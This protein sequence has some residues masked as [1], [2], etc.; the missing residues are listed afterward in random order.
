MKQIEL[1]RGYKALVDDSDFELVN[2]YKWRVN[3][4][5]HGNIY[6]YRSV[7]NKGKR[8]FI[9][10][11][12]MVIKTT[13]QV[14]HID[15]NGLNNQ[16]ENLRAC[17]HTENMR[18]RRLFKNNTSGFKGVIFDKFSG[19]WRT[20]FYCKFTDKI[21]AAKTYDKIAKLIYGKF[22]RL[23]FPEDL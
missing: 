3:V 18:N 22:A 20:T 13:E 23:N 5:A 12:K 8:T 17:T 10:M 6:A 2:K 11:H 14:D 19:K 15:G 9:Y 1:T 7:K 16:K 21:E 4:G